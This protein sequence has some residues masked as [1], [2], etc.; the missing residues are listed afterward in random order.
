MLE[1][2]ASQGINAIPEMIRILINNAM[3]L[4]RQAYLGVAPYERSSQ[5]RD[6]A[7]FEA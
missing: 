6:Q 2:I 1:E 3:L 4:E 7:N 5:R